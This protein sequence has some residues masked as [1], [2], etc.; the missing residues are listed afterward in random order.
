[1]GKV[2][3]K[4]PQCAISFFNHLAILSLIFARFRQSRPPTI[5]S[6]HSFSNYNFTTNLKFA[7]WCRK[8][9]TRISSNHG[10]RRLVTL[11]GEKTTFGPTGKSQNMIVG[12][13]GTILIL[14][15][16]GAVSADIAERRTFC[17]GSSRRMHASGVFL[18]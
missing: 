14:H 3:P 13:F 12:D 17:C 18:H 7:H 15:V 11:R 4:D 6:H 9:D 2:T 10:L 16:S 8:V 5:T 1:M